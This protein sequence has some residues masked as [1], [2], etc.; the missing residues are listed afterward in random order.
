MTATPEEEA[1]AYFKKVLPHLATDEYFHNK[2]KSVT[3]QA[4]LAGYSIAQEEIESIRKAARDASNEQ[5]KETCKWMD[6]AF[7]WQKDFE[8]ERAKVAELVDYQRLRENKDLG[9]WGLPSQSADS[10]RLSLDSEALTAA[11][12][13]EFVKE[14]KP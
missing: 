1:I 2:D 14:E 8:T 10:L 11:M 12:R 4:F 13:A 7:K 6:S 3:I 9:N 5:A